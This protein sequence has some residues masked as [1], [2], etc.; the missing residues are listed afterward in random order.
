[1]EATIDVFLGVEDREMLA[2][3]LR[4]LVALYALGAFVPAYDAS[5]GAEHEDGVITNAFHQDPEALL[6]LAQFPLVAFQ[7]GYGGCQLRGALLNPVF[8]ILVELPD[9]FLCL[10]ALGDVAGHLREAAQTTS[11]VPQGRDQDTRPELRT[12][13]AYPPALFLVGP[14]LLRYL[15]LSLWLAAL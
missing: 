6:A 2:D 8:E 9:L 5:V 11:L 12:I 13:L 15:K 14:L 10:L 1:M 3:D 4:D 7:F